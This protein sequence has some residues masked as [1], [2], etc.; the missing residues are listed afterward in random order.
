MNK[1]DHL[2]MLAVD[3]RLILIIITKLY[4]TVWTGFSWLRIKSSG[5]PM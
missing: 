2:K 4:V 5:K 1:R 3:V